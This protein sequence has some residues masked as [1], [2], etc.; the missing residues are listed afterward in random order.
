MSKEKQ[1]TGE[2]TQSLEEAFEKIEEIIDK[3]ETEEITLEESFT[4]Y[5]QGI[6]KLKE[7]HELLDT[8]EKKMQ[9]LNGDGELE[10]F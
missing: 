6:Q 7:C 8:V 4:L 10:D 1:E 2:N 3:M 5:Q 9:V